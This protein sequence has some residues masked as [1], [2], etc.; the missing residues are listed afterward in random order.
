MKSDMYSK[1]AE[2]YDNVIQRN[3]YNAQFERP[4]TQAM[5][6]EIAGKA[7]LDM[8]CG[9]GVYA[10]YFL[11]KGA[12]S[13]T[14][15]DF[16]AEM[17]ALVEKKFGGKVNAYVQDLSEGLPKEKDATYDVIVCPLVL[18]Y[19]EDLTKV[20]AD[21][22]RVLK[23]G[24]YMVFS[25]HHPFADFECSTTGNYFDRELVQEEWNTV[26]TPVR[27]TFYRRSLTEI[28]SAITDAGLL[29]SQISEGTVNEKIKDES[30]EIYERLSK[31]PSFIFIKCQK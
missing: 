29:I 22:A 15:L 31:Q 2:Q 16:S 11:S 7:V 1:Y 13:V 3:I 10:D 27:V 19:V 12:A 5:L 9:S 21:V 6:G 24:G 4:N 14:C 28:C 8:G 17:I 23:P 26:G 20:F 25:T 30:A 18:H